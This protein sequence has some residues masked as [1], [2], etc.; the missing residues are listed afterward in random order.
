MD[1]DCIRL[2][3][4][5]VTQPRRTQAAHLEI[6]L[7]SWIP[8]DLSRSVVPSGDTASPGSGAVISHDRI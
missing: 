4:E 3:E 2:H 6:L 5:K 8:I 1:P 7:E